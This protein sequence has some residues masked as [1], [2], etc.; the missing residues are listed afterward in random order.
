MAT[1]EHAAGQGDAA[2]LTDIDL[3][4]LGASTS[5][6]ERF[7]RDVRAEYA[8][9][10]D[11]LYARARAHVLT[12]LAA[13]TPLYTTPVIAGELTRRATVNLQGAIARWSANAEL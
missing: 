9:V 10:D 7:E 8:M 2:L 6:F 12:R 1:R 4:I 13:R 11:T 3:S 5:D